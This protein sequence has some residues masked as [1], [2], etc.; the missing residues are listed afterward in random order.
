MARERVSRRDFIKG[1]GTAG[2]AAS[3]AAVFDEAHAAAKAPEAY[4]GWESRQGKVYFDRKPFE[5]DT[6][7]SYEIVGELKRRDT[8]IYD[9]RARLG[10][11]PRKEHA[12]LKYD[13]GDPFWTDFYNT[14]KDDG[15]GISPL[16]KDRQILNEWWP[17]M[18]QLI[19]D[20]EPARR[21][22]GTTGA[23]FLAAVRALPYGDFP[24]PKVD[25]PPEEWDWKD[26]NPL[27]AE[28]KSPELAS[29]WI[30][31]VGADYSATLVRVTRVN[32]AWF[33][34]N[35]LRGVEEDVPVGEEFEIRPWWK[36][37]IVVT[38]PMNFDTLSADPNYGTSQDG[39]N[40]N[41]YAMWHLG[42]AIKALG[43]PAR[44]CSPKQGYEQFMVPF[45]VDAGFGELGRTCNCVA[46]DFGGNFRP[47]IILTNLPLAVDRPINAG[48]FDF[49]KKCKMCAEYCQTAAISMADE[50]NYELA[51][52]RRWDVDGFKCNTG[53]AMVSGT[54]DF[55]EG[56]PGG[57]T[58]ACRACIAACPW[59][60][61][62]NWL[63]NTVRQTVSR[64]PIGLM[65]DVSLQFE[66]GLYHRNPPESFI[67]PQ[68][69][70]VHEPPEWL[71]TENYIKG[72]GDTPLGEG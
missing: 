51:G 68:L 65:D 70:G 25:A 4:A 57:G 38:R 17:P 43:Y 27:R 50:P 7:Q 59:F 44:V 8:R 11:P 49:C 20:G 48:V 26:V 13:S 63:H 34:A 61:R 62:T 64:D 2:A 22:F 47:G 12:L 56:S 45:A 28:F 40:P 60:R 39:Y 1:L 42:Q 41:S 16:E 6:P 72:F 18:D 69:K 14:E 66:R 54:A 10:R 29:Q 31:R 67:A 24:F 23:G 9:T 37:A 3:V 35:G 55:P 33:Y 52:V 71:K 15:D 36:Y 19:K 32:P 21:E 5:V 46:P 53:W 58:S 30:K